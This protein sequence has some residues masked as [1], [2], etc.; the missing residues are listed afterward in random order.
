MPLL[1][2]D[3]L[4]TGRHAWSMETINQLPIEI[5]ALVGRNLPWAVSKAGSGY[6]QWQCYQILPPMSYPIILAGP[7][8]FRL[9]TPGIPY[10]FVWRVTE[11]QPTKAL[12]FDSFFGPRRRTAG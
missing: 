12:F 10:T 8:G 2:G 6:E 7:A 1:Q 5:G 3:K 9:Q 4:Y 11:R